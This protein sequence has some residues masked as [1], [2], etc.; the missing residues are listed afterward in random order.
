MNGKKTFNLFSPVFARGMYTVGDIDK[1][2]ENGRIVYTGQVSLKDVVAFCVVTLQIEKLTMLLWD[3]SCQY[4]P[5]DQLSR[6]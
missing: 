4:W 1:V 5:M 3:H 6:M 2:Y